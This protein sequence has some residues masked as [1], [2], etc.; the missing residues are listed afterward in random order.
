M[1]DSSIIRLSL[2]NMDGTITYNIHLT[3]TVLI[4][5]ER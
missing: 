3:M 1:H 4:S 5:A 2:I